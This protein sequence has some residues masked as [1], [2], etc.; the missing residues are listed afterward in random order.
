MPRRHIR[1]L[2]SGS[3][4]GV[5][6]RLSRHLV[7]AGYDA[8]IGDD[9]DFAALVDRLMPDV[10]VLDGSGLSSDRMDLVHG[11]SQY[12][13]IPMIVLIDKRKAREVHGMC[14]GYDDVLTCPLEDARFLLQILADL[15]GG[16]HRHPVVG[17][18]P[19]PTRVTWPTARR[20]TAVG[21]R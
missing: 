20:R 3:R 7:L 21:S 14:A 12:R 18:H 1:I 16:P 10:L 4:K 11:Q 2:V 8:V 19:F 13:G 6:D 5:T 9:D 15:F 17:V